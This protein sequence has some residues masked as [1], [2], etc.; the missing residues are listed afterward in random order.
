MKYQIWQLPRSEKATQTI[1]TN[2]SKARKKKQKNIHI[3][4]TN[5]ERNKNFRQLPV[6]PALR[7]EEITSTDRERGP[8]VPTIFVIAEKL[9]TRTQADNITHQDPDEPNS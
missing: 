8:S 4:P 3:F 6:I 9:C 7:Q 1:S 5:R 2:T